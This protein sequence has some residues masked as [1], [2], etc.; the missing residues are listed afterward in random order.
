MASESRAAT[1]LAIMKGQAPEAA[2]TRLGQPMVHYRGLE[3]CRRQLHLAW[4]GAPFQYWW[5]LIYAD[6]IALSDGL[7]RMHR[8]GLAVFMDAARRR[9]WWAFPETA[10]DPHSRAYQVN[11]LVELAENS[12]AQTHPFVAPHS[13]A[14]ASMIDPQTMAVWAARMEAAYPAVRGPLGWRDSVDPA[15]GEASPRYHAVDQG[16]IVS[17][18]LADTIRGYLDRVWRAEQKALRARLL[19]SVDLSDSTSCNVALPYLD[20]GQ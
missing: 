2:W 18:M 3:G 20:A 5:P 14:L 11:G 6:E 12:K 13:L 1:L 8:N 16:L 17:S 9:G 10:S 15:T 7:A 4:D 19:A